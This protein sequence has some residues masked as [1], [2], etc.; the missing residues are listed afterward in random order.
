MI[1]YKIPTGYSS[2][3]F[4]TAP[5]TIITFPF[6]FAVM[7]GDAAHGAILL[8]AALFF[9][10]NERK[11]ESKKIRDEVSVFYHIYTRNNFRFSI[12]STAV[13]TL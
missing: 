1:G 11:I 8:L 6:L 2:S 7:F 3:D 12:H 4:F 10:R 13:V 5:Y 9:I